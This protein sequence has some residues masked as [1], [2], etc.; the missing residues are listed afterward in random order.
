MGGVHVGKER[1][2]ERGRER[3]GG[4]KGGVEVANL[5]ASACTSSPASPLRLPPSL[6]L[7]FPS[8]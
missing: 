2:R 7:F 6:S 1:K 4:R 8:L 5:V 3:V